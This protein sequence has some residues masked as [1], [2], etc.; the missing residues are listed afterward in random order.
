MELDPLKTNF[1]A[2]KL[3]FL[4]CLAA[5]IAVALVLGGYYIRMNQVANYIDTQ[6]AQ[7]EKSLKQIQSQSNIG[8]GDNSEK[9]A[10]F[11]FQH[12]L[13]KQTL[14]NEKS[15][16]QIK[17]L[18]RYYISH[19]IES[20]SVDTTI[21]TTENDRV[22]KH[23]LDNILIHNAFM[24]AVMALLP[25]LLLGSHLGFSKEM[26]ATYSMRAAVVRKSWWMKFLIGFILAYGWVYVINPYGRGAGAIEQFLIA[27]DLPQQDTLPVFIR[28]IQ[29]KPIMAGFLG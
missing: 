7:V 18:L 14:D 1:N 27:L 3:T 25:F 17:H 19:R 5:I 13:I 15:S 22:I 29:I 11:L 28:D 2:S 12:K 4:Y 8:D 20:I 16:N 23:E 24:I 26:R 21:H 10:E 6:L 9:F